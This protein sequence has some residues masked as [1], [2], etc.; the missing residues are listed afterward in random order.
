M[1]EFIYI[2]IGLK[3]GREGS[4][5]LFFF[6]AMLEIIEKRKELKGGAFNPSTWEEET[7]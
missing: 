7:G 1:Y 6:M 2:K 4:K 3:L 5:C